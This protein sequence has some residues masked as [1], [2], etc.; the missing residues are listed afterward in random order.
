MAGTTTVK[1][2]EK[3]IITVKRLVVTAFMAAMTT[4]MTAYI[5]H[6]PLGINEGYI[7]LGDAVIYIAAAILPA[8]YA[9]VAGAIGGGLADLLTA[10]VWAP[11]TIIIKVLITIPFTNQKTKI[12]NTR[13]V[14]ALFIALVINVVGYFLA[15]GIMYGFTTAFFVSVSGNLVQSIGSAVVFIL[16]GFSLDKVHF[17]ARFMKEI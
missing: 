12:I 7:H 1:T 9:M 3:E 4:L 6:I 15:E 8:P 17:K 2:R 13:N 11:A 16:F 14:A 5:C 10:P